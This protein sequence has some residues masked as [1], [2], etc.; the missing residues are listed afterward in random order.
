MQLQELPGEG[1]RLDGLKHAL[2]D[3]GYRANGGIDAV[4]ILSALGAKFE[5]P[6]LE[7]LRL[8][9]APRSRKSV[10]WPSRLFSRSNSL[11]DT[12][13]CLML[14]SLIP[15]GI[16][17][18]PTTRTTSMTI[19]LRVPRGY[20][21]KQAL[22]TSGTIREQMEMALAKHSGKIT[23]AAAALGVAPATLVSQLLQSGATVPLSPSVRQRLGESRLCA[24]EE[25]LASGTPK[26]EIQQVHRVS[27]W[28]LSLIE[29][30]KPDLRQEH[31]AA[32]VERQRENHRQLVQDYL[33]A[34]PC[35]TR[36]EIRR[37]CSGAIDWLEKFD[38]QWLASHWPTRRVAATKTR[39]A[40]IDWG[41]RDQL[42]ADDVAQL[43]L[44][45]KA[46]S[47]RPMRV[48][49]TRLLSEVGA[50][51]ALDA[52]RGRLPK[53]L[54]AAEAHAESVEDYQRRRLR[55]ALLEHQRLGTPVSTNLTRRISA[56]P[57]RVLMQHGA[58]IV[59]LAK[60]LNVP[61]DA[62]CSIGEQGWRPSQASS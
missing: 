54:R 13:R 27:E 26:R 55:W 33:Q 21:S 5:R 48:T 52:G 38:R 8:A 40:I 45:W 58:Y 28:T 61:I 2:M 15:G 50:L 30:A 10:L 7:H 41:T 16:L 22:G 34:H 29:L 49:R 37:D 9:T 59:Q 46:E 53:T 4:G 62:R 39:K 32:T 20:G 12:L 19:E 57:P 31:R 44:T 24:V 42:L 60:E 43:A 56:F 25:A 6:F 1:G 11:P 3:C 14:T 47:D 17:A 51:V 35:A 18:V 36:V 23:V